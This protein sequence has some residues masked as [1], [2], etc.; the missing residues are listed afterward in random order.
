MLDYFRQHQ[1]VLLFLGLAAGMA[2]PARAESPLTAQG[3]TAFSAGRYTEALNDWQRAAQVGDGQAALYIGLLNDLGRGVP[4]D[5]KA[6]LTWYERAA[7]LG[8]PLAMF[9]IGV[10]YD[11][12]VGISRNHLVAADWYRKA[13]AQGVGRAA[14]ALGLMYE[15]GDGVANDRDEAVRYFRQALASGITAARPHLASLS[16]SNERVRNDKAAS[17]EL[18]KDNGAE[19]FGRAQELLLRSTPEALPAAVA[20]L[21]Q[22]AD[23]G[24]SA[25]AYNLG[26]CYENGIGAEAD[27]HQAYAWYR[28]AAQ[29]PTST[30]RRA[31]LAAMKKLAPDPGPSEVSES[32]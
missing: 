11:S 28:R 13:A 26:Y 29:S 18:P 4:K 19:E 2:M 17:S 10:L 12:G 5:V 8:N 6:A 20:L 32:K 9:N 16:P 24:D 31:A 21:R 1:L 7:A 25:A 30:V 15:A 3:L 23:K 22:A 27:R 14:Y